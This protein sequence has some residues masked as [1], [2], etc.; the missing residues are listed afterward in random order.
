MDASTPI[1]QTMT[2]GNRYPRQIALLRVAI[3]VWLT[4]LTVIFYN[5]GHGGGWAWLLLVL[6]GV[7]FVL[8]LRLV[9]IARRGPGRQVRVH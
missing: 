4:V 7:H 2:L 6:A 3:G 8:A 5:S 1:E 9:R